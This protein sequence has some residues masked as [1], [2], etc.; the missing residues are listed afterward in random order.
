MKLLVLAASSV[1][2]IIFF[3]FM[4]VL[5]PVSA[6]MLPHLYFV[7]LM[8]GLFVLALSLA[9]CLNLEHF[10][11]N[12]SL[13]KFFYFMGAFLGAMVWLIGFKGDF[14]LTTQT[15]ELLM[16]IPLVSFISFGLLIGTWLG[17]LLDSVISMLKN[18]FTS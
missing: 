16:I 14:N 18:K 3:T 5:L 15:L 13:H 6:D 4:G 12:A 8:S 2:L 17:L 10:F 9:F 1:A 11:K 7:K